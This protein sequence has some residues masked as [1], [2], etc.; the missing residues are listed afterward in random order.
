MLSGGEPGP[1]K[2]Q[3]V[4]AGFVPGV[5]DT[6]LID[7]VIRVN[8][9]EAG[10]MARR[11]AKDLGKGLNETN[12]IVAHLGGGISIVALERGRALEA[13]NGLYVRMALLRM[14]L[15]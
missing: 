6:G 15:G 8:H 1:H 7:E 14:I 12:V 10:A 13:H 5:L 2:I 11:A 9:E 3:G 4:G